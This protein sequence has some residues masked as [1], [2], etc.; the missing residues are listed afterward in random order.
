[1]FAQSL[2]QPG[3]CI[4]FQYENVQLLMFTDSYAVLTYQRRILFE[5]GKIRFTE[6]AEYI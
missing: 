5:P 1:M 4:H 3:Q 2:N 6:T